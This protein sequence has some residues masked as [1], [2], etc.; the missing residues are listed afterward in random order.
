MLLPPPL[1]LAL[2]PLAKFSA[3]PL[4]LAKLPLATLPEPPVT[5]AKRYLPCEVQ[6]MRC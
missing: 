6:N 2:P 1:M 4:T 5:V 3:P